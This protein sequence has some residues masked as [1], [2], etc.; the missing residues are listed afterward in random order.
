MANRILRDWTD[1]DKMSSLS[2]HAERFFTRLI[3]KVDDYGCFYADTRLLKANLFPLLLDTIRE[4]D[5]TRWIAE[6]KTAGL[7]VL[8]EVNKKCYV[9]INDFRQRLDKARHKYPLPSDNDSVEIVIDIP[10]ET[11]TNPKPKPKKN[12]ETEKV[13]VRENV[14]LLPSEIEKLKEKFSEE[15]IGWMYDKLSNYKL[16]KGEVYKSDYG[17]INSWVKDALNKEKSFAKKENN[18][19]ESK[20]SQNAAVVNNILSGLDFKPDSD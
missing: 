12:P 8:Y 14:S 20:F 7:I 3:M 2:V 1:S 16:S 13:F 19:T 17:A 9:Q 10:A 11:E 18:G 4:A 6:C 15:E 5:I